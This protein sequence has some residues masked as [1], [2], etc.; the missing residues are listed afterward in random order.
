MFVMVVTDLPEDNSKYDAT[1]PARQ[2]RDEG[3]K[4]SLNLFW[5]RF[6]GNVHVHYFPTAV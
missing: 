5:G 6:E 1:V 4:V 2:L 3:V